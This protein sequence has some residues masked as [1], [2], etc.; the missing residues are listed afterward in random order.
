VLF[1]RL[2]L[3]DAGSVIPDLIRDRHDRQKL[4]TILNYDTVWNAGIQ[5]FQMDMDSGYRIESGTSPA[6]VTGIETF[7]DF[8]KFSLSFFVC[9]S[10]RDFLIIISCFGNWKLDIE[11]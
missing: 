6:G 9:S 10:F 2:A 7:Y 8:V 11:I 5:S 3:L 4:N 1:Q